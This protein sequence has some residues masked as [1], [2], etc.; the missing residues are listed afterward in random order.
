M[1]QILPI[2]LIVFSLSGFSQ[3]ITGRFT[4]GLTASQVSGDKSAKFN[5]V[6]FVVGPGAYIPFNDQMGISIDLLYIQKGSR[7]PFTERDPT[8]YKLIL[9]YVEVPFLFKYVFNEKTHFQLGPSFATLIKS[10][11]EDGYGVIGSE[12][13]FKNIELALQVG[14]D[15]MLNEKLSSNL[16]FSNSIYYIREPQNQ[17]RLARYWEKG[18]FITLLS[19]SLIYNF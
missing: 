12:I 1:K 19:L 15:F 2:L 18:Q 13:P 8:F 6:G 5:K 10:Q 4:G 3:N 7:K 14:I 16:R 9:N 17:S 11:E